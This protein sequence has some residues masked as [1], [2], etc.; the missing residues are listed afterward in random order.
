MGGDRQC[1]AIPSLLGHQLTVLAILNRLTTLY[2]TLF[3]FT[4]FLSVSFQISLISFRLPYNFNILLSSLFISLSHLHIQP[5]IQYHY[6][7]WP[8][9]AI[10]PL[11]PIW[12]YQSTRSHIPEN[13]NLLS[14]YFFKS[15][16]HSSYRQQNYKILKV[17]CCIVKCNFFYLFLSILNCWTVWLYTQT[18]KGTDIHNYIY[19]HS[20][21]VLH[22]F[23]Y[24]HLHEIQIIWRDISLMN[25][26]ASRKITRQ[27]T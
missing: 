13:Y 26:H 2:L 7:Y 6:S 1:W 23:I 18:L 24:K 12:W 17:W 22:T 14:L 5:I 9:I 27:A 11:P 15:L 20:P 4:P 10:V 3:S 19:A 25:W 21:I 8:D 16:T